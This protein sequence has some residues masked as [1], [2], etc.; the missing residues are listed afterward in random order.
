M[1]KFFAF[2][3]CCCLLC[4]FLPVRHVL[5]EEDIASVSSPYIMP[6]GKEGREALLCDSNYKTFITIQRDL[7]LT[8]S[9][10][11]GTSTVLLEWFSLP[12]SYTLEYLD[13]SGKVLDTQNRTPITYHEYIEMGEAASLRLSSRVKLEVAEL[14]TLQKEEAVYVSGY[15]PCDVVLLLKEPG[16]E[17]T[18][19]APVLQYFLNKGLTIQICYVLSTN[20][21]RMGEVMDS[22]QFL[23]IE[24]E[25]VFLSMDTPRDDSY[26][27]AVNRWNEKDLRDAASTLTILSPKII[28]ADGSGSSEYM[29][30]ALLKQDV[31]PDKVYV[32]DEEGDTSCELNTEEFSTME[33]ALHLQSSQRIYKLTPTTL[34]HLRSTQGVGG[35]LLDG[36]DT[37]TFLTY[38]TPTPA[39]TDTPAPTNTPS[40]APTNTA[41]PADTPV[42]TVEPEPS[43]KEFSS[44]WLSAPVL[45]I[46]LAIVVMMILHKKKKT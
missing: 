13:N 21:D 34:V 5:A 26:G 12:E 43:A 35:E 24:R 25:P 38:A 42:P 23:G 14:R 28:V 1:K 17:C 39:P 3:L 46:L 40:P 31:S 44:L 20:R 22:L 6:K 7:S 41:M 11:V 9:P 10:E 29:L 27:A 33:S 30:E 18:T 45:L 36:L 16:Q 15:T 4:T 19:A 32:L 37:S 2:I 8:F